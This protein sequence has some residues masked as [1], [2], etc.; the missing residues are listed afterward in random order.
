MAIHDVVELAA[1]PHMVMEYVEGGTLADLITPDAPLAPDRV[2]DLGLQVCRAL[3]YAHARGVV[4][5]DIKPRNILIGRNGE[6]KVSDFGIARI[7]GSRLTQTGA[8]L[9][10]PAYMSPEQVRGDGV[11]GRS[12]LF[13]LGA[14]LYE[15]LTGVETFPGDDLATVVYHIVHV[16][17]VPLRTLN[18]S[19]SPALEAAVQRALARRRSTVTQMRR[20]SRRPWRTQRPVPHRARSPDSLGSARGAAA[21]AC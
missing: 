19:I 2:V 4:H 15:A 9:G 1:G 16:E 10:S 13:S 8:M 3:S 18:P 6:A 11:D 5:R 21:A 7:S 17:P 20:H 14:V 12:D